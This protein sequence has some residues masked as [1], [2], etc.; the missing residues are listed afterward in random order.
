[1]KKGRK[2]FETSRHLVPEFETEL[3]QFRL[4]H[5]C[6]HLN[7]SA[8]TSI[9]ILRCERCRRYLSRD[10]RLSFRQNLRKPLPKVLSEEGT[11]LNEPENLTEP[12][13][14]N[15]AVIQGLEVLW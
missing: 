14:S 1:M 15:R 10:R 2:K 7:E 11:P 12:S 5:H 4:C 6:L 3:T 9:D 8:S 13:L